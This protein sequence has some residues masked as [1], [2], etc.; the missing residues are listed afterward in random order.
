MVTTILPQGSEYRDVEDGDDLPNLALAQV[1]RQLYTEASLLPY[2]VIRFKVVG[3][4]P[5]TQGTRYVNYYYSAFDLWMAQRT[6][7]QLSVITSIAPSMH[8][9]Q[10]YSAG[11]RPAFRKVFPGLWALDLTA[12]SRVF[13]DIYVDVSTWTKVARQKDR[14]IS[15]D[16][17]SPV[18]RDEWDVDKALE[19]Y[20]IK[21]PI[22]FEA[23]LGAQSD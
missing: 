20:L 7:A 17:T 6:P 14:E 1:I 22:H 15:L 11:H 12:A 16:I 5:K 19:R 18:E 4:L 8:Y 23:I 9:L 10:R 13:D 3:R 2:M 21:G